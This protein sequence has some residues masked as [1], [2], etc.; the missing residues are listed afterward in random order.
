MLVAALFAAAIGTQT[1]GEIFQQAKEA[2]DRKEPAKALT[3]LLP[4]APEAPDRCDAES[5]RAGVPSA[6]R[7]G[8]RARKRYRSGPSVRERDRSRPRARRRALQPRKAA[9]RPEAVSRGRGGVSQADRARAERRLRSAPSGCGL[10]R[11]RESGGGSSGSPKGAR[12]PSGERAVFASPGGGA[13]RPRSLPGLDRGF[14]GSDRRA[15]RTAFPFE[16]LS[17]APGSST[18]T[19]RRPPSTCRRSW[20]PVSRPRLSSSTSVIVF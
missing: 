13:L 5:A 17:R 9:P 15:G 11:E 7:R 4:L 3:L 19:S 20:T 18:A 2:L 10:P 14:R 12:A 8:A 16:K 1:A 6:R